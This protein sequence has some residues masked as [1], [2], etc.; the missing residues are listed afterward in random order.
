METP[1]LFA[2]ILSKPE[3]V[4]YLIEYYDFELIEPNSDTEK[5]HFKVDEQV[6]IIAQDVSG[7]IFSLIGSGE[8][9]KRPVL[10]IDSE[11]KAGKVGKSFN[12]FISLMLACPYWRDLLKFSG[13]GQMTEM[14]KTQ[15]FLESEIVEDYLG[16]VDI[17]DKVMTELLIEELSHPVDTLY[18]S[19]ISQPQI[20]VFSLEGDKYD[21]LFN[22]FVV[23]N[24]PQWKNKIK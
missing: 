12:G 18:E 17:K 4:N 7:G 2:T 6:A 15:P 22:S 1:K 20:S 9:E 14:M 5:F 16:L 19:M 21:S 8:V 11:G 10:Y 23:T 24:H 13:N 3:I